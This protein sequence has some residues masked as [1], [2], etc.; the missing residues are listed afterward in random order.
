MSNSR[1]YQ[2]ERAV[3]K[4]LEADGW[5]VVRPGASL[6]PAD[7][8]AL[9]KGERPRVIQ[10]KSGVRNAYADFRPKERAALIEY[11]AAAG[12]A[13]ELAWWPVRGALEWI[14]SALW[15]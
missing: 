4:L 12:A 10:V 2:R 15:P 11:A 3:R 8:L 9:K 13:A 14:D 1:G 5:V 6:G 7:L